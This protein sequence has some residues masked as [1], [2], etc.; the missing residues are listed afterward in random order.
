MAKQTIGIGST[1][2]DGTG[3]VL[4]T[5]FNKTNDNFD[6]LY[7]LTEAITPVGL[8]GRA[9]AVWT[10][11]G[12]VFDVVYPIYWIGGIQYAAGI[13]QITLDAADV[14]NPRLDVLALDATGVIKITGTPS[15]DPVKPTIDSETQI[16]VTTILVAANATTPEEFEDEDVYKENIG[17]WTGSSTNG[18]TDFNNATGPLAGTK[19]VDI[20]AYTDGQTITFTRTSAIDATDYSLLRLYIKVKSSLLGSYI[21]IRLMN[22][23]T[24]VGYGPIINDGEYGFIAGSASGYQLIAIPMSDFLLASSSFDK[25]RLELNGS[26]AQGFKLD[27]IALQS[28]AISVSELQDA[29]TSISTPDGSANADG[30]NDTINFSGS[31][32]EISASG[33]DVLFE[34][35]LADQTETEAAGNSSTS[36]GSDNTKTVSSRGVW[37]FTEARRLL[38]LF[39]RWIFEFQDQTGTTYTPVIGDS[40]KII[41]CTNS[42]GITVTIPLNAAVAYAIG[43]RLTFR[44][45]GAGVISFSTTG[46]TVN[47]PF[48]VVKTDGI[49]TTVTWIKRGTNTWDVETTRQYITQD[50]KKNY[51]VAS[52]TTTYTVTLDPAPTSM[53]AG[54]KISVLFTNGNSGSNATLNANGTGAFMIVKGTSMP[55]NPDDIPSGELLDLTFD[56]SNWRIDAKRALQ[57]PISPIPEISGGTVQSGM[58]GLKNY[59]DLQ[60]LLNSTLRRK[61]R[62]IES[63]ILDLNSS[64]VE[65]VAVSAGNSIYNVIKI[66]VDMN[67]ATTPY[68][69]NT[70]VSVYIGGVLVH[71][72][73]GLLAKTTRYEETVVIDNISGDATDLIEQPITVKVEGGDPTA[74]DGFLF[75]QVN[76]EL[77]QLD[78]FDLSTQAVLQVAASDG[79]ALPSSGGQL[80]L[81]DL[82]VGLKDDGLWDTADRIFVLATDGDSDFAIIDIKNPL[83]TRASKVNSPTFVPKEGFDPDGSTSYI[84]TNFNTASDGFNFTQN[85]GSFIVFSL[86]TGATP[87][88]SGNLK[89]RVGIT[90]TTLLGR[91]NA[92]S[93][94]AIAIT[95]PTGLFGATRDT[96]GTYYRRAGRN[97]INSGTS[98]SSSAPTNAT[99]RLGECNGAFSTN[100]HCFVWIGKYLSTAE[101]EALE[102]LVEAYM[103]G[104]SS[105]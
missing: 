85:D 86:R 84:D 14:T 48:T 102:T 97:N 99:I 43:S 66:H 90:A 74:G 60:I 35:V 20:G 12:L 92:S 79:Y 104:M 93:H 100:N 53:T 23:A 80:F 17:D 96:G 54:F 19:C 24:S 49:N 61:Y 70:D 15:A 33:K 75:M 91:V 13:D 10:G 57:I 3:D 29:V 81:N 88:D 18:T 26:N 27:N 52:G 28:G 95:D 40:G 4:R 63:V 101:F 6:E 45:G 2:N 38:S 98:Q 25:I 69:T 65:V 83:G 7:A 67:P 94:V 47:S 37:W 21:R 56:G 1:T 51:A 9:T 5:A 42:S 78:D 44:Q 73:V 22:G 72:F 103:T 36:S 31:G 34:V 71:T 64:P 87:G 32:I 59:T 68:A 11:V 58:Q 77:V 105:L 30:P 89:T 41:R 76:Y 82:I 46:L 55:V 50:G 8:V 62:F 16:E 39:Y